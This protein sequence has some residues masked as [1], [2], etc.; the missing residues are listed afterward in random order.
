MFLISEY[1]YQDSK[2]INPNILDNLIKKIK[3]D[4]KDYKDV[5]YYKPEIKNE[6]VYV[7]TGVEALDIIRTYFGYE[8]YMTV[9]KEEKVLQKEEK[10]YYRIG[11]QLAITTT[12]AIG[13]AL[14]EVYRGKKVYSESEFLSKINQL[15]VQI[16]KDFTPIYI[17]EKLR[18]YKHKQ[19]RTAKIN[20]IQPKI[21]DF[22]R[23]YLQVVK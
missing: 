11:G 17:P 19:L 9:T 15:H 2:N 12:L 10:K 23:K 6:Q 18:K 16:S 20:E 1:I 7:G 13:I 14:Y 22:T 3:K 4:K 5:G 8:T 21:E